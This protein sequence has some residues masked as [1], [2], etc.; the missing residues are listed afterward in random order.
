M[1]G[2]FICK[3]MTDQAALTQHHIF[4]L[5]MTAEEAS[6]ISLGRVS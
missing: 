6:L 1:V 2:V 4:Y 3:I 5:L